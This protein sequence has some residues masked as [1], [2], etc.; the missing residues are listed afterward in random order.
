MSWNAASSVNSCARISNMLESED[1]TLLDLIK[2]DS[3]KN[4]LKRQ[5]PH[6]F[7]FLIAHVD[8]L[9]NI[10]L[11]VTQTD[12]PPAQKNCFSI[13]ITQIQAFT[14]RLIDNNVL[15]KCLNDFI[16]TNETLTPAGAATFSRI[17]QFL[18]QAS[19]SKIFGIF[20]DSKNLFQKLLKHVQHIAITNLLDFITD[21]ENKTLLITFLEDNSATEVL[22][23]CISD[24]EDK[25]EKIFLF[26]TNIVASITNDSP[27]LSPFEETPT[28]NKIFQKIMTT[29]SPHTASKAINLWYE[30]TTQCESEEEEANNEDPLYESV[31]KLIVKKIP[32]LCDF[33]G[34]SKPFLADKVSAVELL[35]VLIL[36]KIEIE[37]CVKDL[38]GKLFNQIFEFPSHTI[39]QRSFLTL[40][41]TFIVHDK[42][43]CLELIDK[44]NMRPR[45]IEVFDKRYQIDVSYWGIL[46]NI[47]AE[48]IKN[49]PELNTKD[50]KWA[51]FA[52]QCIC[53]MKEVIQN[54]YGGEVPE[55]NSE[56]SEN[57]DDMEFPLG[58]SQ[59]SSL[60]SVVTKAPSK[61]NRDDDDGDE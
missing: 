44:I 54:G 53:S 32:E 37:Q 9:I 40:F 11:G 60:S 19:D 56:E 12:Y 39:L 20:P 2:D 21:C 26:L 1:C 34:S 14:N 18:I 24:D 38:I 33:I 55:E 31:F 61:F 7:D 48:I 59:K 47:S 13:I 28:M 52:A 35:N 15:M 22:I 4:A 30:L 42:N 43:S 50:P 6:L 58:N 25:N 8:E 3:I 5:I 46:Y 57:D 10:A 49:Y 17:L 29:S 27:L 51:H 23:K 36:S 45:I 16:S 41:N